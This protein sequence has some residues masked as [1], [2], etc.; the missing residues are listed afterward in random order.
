MVTLVVLCTAYVIPVFFHGKNGY[1]NAPLCYVTRTLPVFYKVTSFTHVS[2]VGMKT[3]QFVITE[4]PHKHL[5]TFPGK[6]VGECQSVVP[7]LA[8]CVL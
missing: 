8:L 7:I 5:S 1:A 4:T 3:A 6:P 2:G